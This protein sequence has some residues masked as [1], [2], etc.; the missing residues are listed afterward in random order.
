MHYLLA[1]VTRIAKNASGQIL[2][3]DSFGLFSHSPNAQFMGGR[4]LDP[5]PTFP[6]RRM[7]DQDAFRD[8]GISDRVVSEVN[9]VISTTLPFTVTE[10]SG[11]IQSISIDGHNFSLQDL[12]QVGATA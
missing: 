8:S 2:R 10:T 3:S 11:V 12:V 4:S 1:Q 5:Q 6:L 7:S 9:T